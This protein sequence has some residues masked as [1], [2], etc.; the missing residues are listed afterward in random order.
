MR[1]V[2]IRLSKADPDV[3]FRKHGTHHEYIACFVDNGIAVSKDP[4]AV[5]KELEKNYIMKGVGKPKHYVGGDVVELQNH[6]TSKAYLS[7]IVSQTYP[8]CVDYQIVV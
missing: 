7:R 8:L 4:K 1:K 2:G 6:G 5:I 3:W